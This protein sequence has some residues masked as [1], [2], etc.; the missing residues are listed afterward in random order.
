MFFELLESVIIC[1]DPDP[2][3]NKTGVNVQTVSN[4]LIKNTF[5]CWHFESHRRKK[6]DP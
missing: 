6:Q 4:K 5:L 3:I 2:Y 1:T